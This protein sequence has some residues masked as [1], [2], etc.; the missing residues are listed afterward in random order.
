MKNA[1]EKNYFLELLIKALEG[2]ISPDEVGL[3][4]KF[5]KADDEAAYLYAEFFDTIS[6]LVDLNERSF[7]FE[8]TS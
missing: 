8:F 2:Q 4:N 5:I 7:S 3:L 6:G 1:N